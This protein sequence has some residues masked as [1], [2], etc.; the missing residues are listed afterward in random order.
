MFKGGVVLLVQRNGF[1]FKLL[2]TIKKYVAKGPGIFSH[3]SSH[4]LKFHICEVTY[5][6]RNVKQA[7][8][9]GLFYIGHSHKTY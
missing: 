5:N 9:H 4:Y 3:I 2:L 1:D 6:I 7:F 8:F